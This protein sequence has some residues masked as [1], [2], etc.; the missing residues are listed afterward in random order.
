MHLERENGW[1]YGKLTCPETLNRFLLQSCLEGLIWLI[2][3]FLS[4]S[5]PSL[6]NPAV[7]KADRNGKEECR[8]KLQNTWDKGGKLR[9]RNSIAVPNNFADSF[10]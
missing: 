3:N 4:T 5:E 1:R 6:R 10:F 9:Q 8:L 7:W 2:C